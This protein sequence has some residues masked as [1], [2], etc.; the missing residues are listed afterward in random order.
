MKKT[1]YWISTIYDN[2]VKFTWV[3]DPKKD[4]PL[5]T[6][7]NSSNHTVEEEEIEEDEAV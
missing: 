5:D 1:R 2:G 6:Y 4:A 3:Y 7:Q